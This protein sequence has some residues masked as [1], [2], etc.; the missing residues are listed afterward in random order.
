MVNVIGTAKTGRY[1]KEGGSGKRTPEQNQ[2][3]WILRS[4]PQGPLYIG[5]VVNCLS[6]D[7]AIWLVDN[8]PEGMTIAEYFSALLDDAMDPDDG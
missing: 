3:H 1:G 5:S 8:V 7:Q 4:R 2:I 6:M